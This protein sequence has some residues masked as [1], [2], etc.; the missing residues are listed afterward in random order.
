MSSD[1]ASGGI[2]TGSEGEARREG[3]PEAS[4]RP[5]RCNVL[6]LSFLSLV[7]IAFGLWVVSAGKLYREEYSQDMEGWRI[8]SSREVDITL[9]KEDDRNLACASDRVIG[10]LRCGYRLNL[11]AAGAVS[12]AD[13]QM[14]QPYNTVG[15][16]L[17][18]GAGLWT[19]PGMKQPLPAGRFTVTCTYNIRGMVRAAAIRFA[20][21]A[22]FDRVG[23]TVPVGALSDCTLPR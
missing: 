19:S 4:L 14:L 17:L 20:P 12:P 18:L 8:G 23:R 22:P 21:T 11:Q 1:P 2:A 7:L 9:V 3:Q 10:G 5:G 6:L 15:S 16:Q 13:P